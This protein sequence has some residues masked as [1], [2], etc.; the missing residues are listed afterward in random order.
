MSLGRAGPLDVM[1]DFR[2]RH[3]LCYGVRP[4]AP[5]KVCMNVRVNVGNYTPYPTGTSIR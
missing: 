1:E 5:F 2:C 3:H 4:G